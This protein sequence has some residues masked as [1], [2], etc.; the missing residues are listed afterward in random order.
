[1]KARYIASAVGFALIATGFASAQSATSP[2]LG[3]ILSATPVLRQGTGDAIMALVVLSAERSNA[4]IQTTSVP[5]TMS[6][7]GGLTAS[8]LTDCRIRNVNSL[9]SALN[10][11]SVSP[12][13]G[14]NTFTYDTPLQVDAGKV[15]TLALTCDIASTAPSGGTVLLSLIPANV[16][17]TVVGSSTTITPTTGYTLNGN[18]G[19]TAGSVLLSSSAGTGGPTIPGAPNT[20]LGGTANLMVILASAI[21]M[22]L[23]VVLL[24]RR[25]A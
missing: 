14:L 19:P 15:A 10:Q 16:P 9:S 6:F 8:S 25:M 21:A 1:M 7:G 24:R 3:V 5:V 18:L 22:I 4:A 20:G 2:S 12:S 11:T 23:G 13:P 17:A